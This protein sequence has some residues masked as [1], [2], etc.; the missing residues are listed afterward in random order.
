MAGSLRP[1][2][3]REH[4]VNHPQR[5][6]GRHLPYQLPA[7][8]VFTTTRKLGAS[9]YPSTKLYSLILG[10]HIISERLLR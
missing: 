5:H 2:F 9:I 6:A 1:V 8:H 7:V 4:L 3:C 10:Q